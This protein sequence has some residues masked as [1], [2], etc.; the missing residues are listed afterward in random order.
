MASI[1]IIDGHPDPDRDHFVHALADAYAEG[2]ARRHSVE[3]ID[4]ATLDFPLL[5]SAKEWREGTPV[6]AIAAAQ[7]AILHASKV[8][9]VF[10]LWL[11]DVPALL[12]GFLEQVFRPGFAMEMGES[13]FPKRLLKGRS[14]RL[15]VTMGMPAPF[16]RFFYRAHSVKSLERNILSFVGFAP[17]RRSLIG[18]V[19]GSDAA[20]QKWLDRMRALG[21]AGQ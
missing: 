19:E 12:K 6:P 18:N 16:Y 10:P 3:R 14:A 15:V 20:R 2:A 4:L 5:R 1:V 7:Q 21:A 8:V 9:I 11:G 17:V 13:G